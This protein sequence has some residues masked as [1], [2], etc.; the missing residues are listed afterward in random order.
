MAGNWSDNFEVTEGVGAE[1]LPG[2][3]RRSVRHLAERYLD[4]REQLFDD[5]I[6]HGFVR[7]GHGDLIADDIYCLDDGPRVLDCLAFSDELRT[8]DVLADVGFL[9]MDLAR[10]GHPELGV[11]LM[12]DYQEFSAEHHPSSLAHHYVAYRAHVRAKVACLAHAQGQA[13]ADELAR[14]YHD[15]AEEH[16]QRGVVRLVILG[17]APGVGKSTVSEQLSRRFGWYRLSTD[18]IRKDLAGLGHTTRA[19]APV[20]DALYTPE[21]V[22]DTYRELLRQAESLL[23]SG[24]SVVLDA[25]WS[26]EAERERARLEAE[27][28]CSDL[29]EIE[30]T[31]DAATADARIRRRLD[32]GESSSDV[33]PAVASELRAR[34]D[35]WPGA[36]RLPTAGTE[37]EVD[38]AAAE[39]LGELLGWTGQ[40]F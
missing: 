2:E 28:T 4:G 12:R 21:R 35:A 5:R 15:L 39:L 11:S 40:R 38:S 8:C 24:C 10:L 25:S 20:D 33:T 14:S 1:I 26:S 37:D 17:G 30:C 23:R 34:R 22:A 32:A 16:L 31:L 7:E 36:R 29:L 27:R 9:A 13:G 19:S 6:A 18:D 3:Q